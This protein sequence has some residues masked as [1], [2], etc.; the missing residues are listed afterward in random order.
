MCARPRR[1]TE[2]QIIHAAEVVWSCKTIAEAARELDIS[3]QTLYTWNK[4]DA[5]FKDTLKRMQSERLAKAKEKVGAGKASILERE[6]LAQDIIADQILEALE[7][8]AIPPE[9]LPQVQQ[10]LLNNTQLRQEKPT[11]IEGKMFEI[12][13]RYSEMDIGELYRKVTELQGMIAE[14]AQAVE[15]P[16][17]RYATKIADAEPESQQ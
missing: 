9:K 3:A 10:A 12:V 8:R 13:K 15:N 5:T 16:Y 7:N 17:Q 4:E 2:E 14:A 1:F 11:A 6:L